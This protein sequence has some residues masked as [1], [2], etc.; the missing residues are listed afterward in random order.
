MAFPDPPPGTHDHMLLA[1]ARHAGQ[2]FP[3]PGGKKRRWPFVLAAVLALAIL[4]GAVYLL[5][6]F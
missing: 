6:F 5:F 4:A 1:G 3:L 2:V